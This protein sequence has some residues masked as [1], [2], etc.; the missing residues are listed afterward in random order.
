MAHF[1]KWLFV[2]SI[3]T[4]QLES[5]DLGVYGG[6]AS[7]KEE[8][9]L[10]FINERIKHFSIE[11]QHAFGENMR[12]YFTSQLKKP[13]EVKGL[14]KARAYA[15]HYFDPSI[16]IDRD[17]YNTNQQLI[18]KKGTHFNPLAQVTLEHSLIFFDATDSEQLVWAQQQDPSVKW[19]LVKGEPLKLE[20]ELK[21]PIYFDQ[22]GVLTKKFCIHSVPSKVSQDGLK[23]KVEAIPPNEEACAA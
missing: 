5:K 16:S 3:L 22:Q 6:V 19:I 20:E 1:L 12:S 2:V 21:R 11:E 10:H 14:R 4:S 9:L 8:D 18:V 17:I 15:V 13:M 7:I 23:L